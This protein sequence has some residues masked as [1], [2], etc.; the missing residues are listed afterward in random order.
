MAIVDIRP[1][2]RINLTGR[3][4][5]VLLAMAGVVTALF[6]VGGALLL[7][8]VPHHYRLSHTAAGPYFVDSQAETEKKPYPALDRYREWLTMSPYLSL[9]HI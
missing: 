1:E 5:A 8:A 7:A 6:V 3:E 2:R 9:I 4:R